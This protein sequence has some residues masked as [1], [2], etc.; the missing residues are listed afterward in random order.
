[1][2]RKFV[3]DVDL[4]DPDLDPAVKQEFRNR[5]L[6]RAQAAKLK[7]VQSGF[8]ADVEDGQIMSMIE[9]IGQLD[10]DDAGGWDF[11]GASSGAVFLRRMKEHFRGMLGPTEKVPFLPRPERPPGLMHIE[12][13]QSGASSPFDSTSSLSLELPSKDEIK[14]LSYYSLNCAT[15]LIRIVHIPSFYEQLDAI[16]DKTYDTLTRDEYH[17]LG[18]V[19][20]VMA[21]GCMYRNLDP[22][23]PQKAAYRE[24]LQE[25]YV[26]S[27]F[28]PRHMTSRRK[29]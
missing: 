27:R 15:C 24:A 20:A 12:S 11:H 7:Q 2:L 18:L 29:G 28:P 6:A 23:K 16:Y 13:P 21:L 25:G 17:F 19:Y 22:E 10:L 5:E 14:D 1:M 9:S 26:P 3:P 4:S 8:D